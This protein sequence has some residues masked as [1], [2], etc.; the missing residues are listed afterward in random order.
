MR[1]AC[2]SIVTYAP[3]VIV[4]RDPPPLSNFKTSAFS[5]EAVVIEVRIHHDNGDCGED[6][7][8]NLPKQVTNSISLDDTLGEVVGEVVILT[9]VRMH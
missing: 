1:C 3:F 2:C 5:K 4:N 6:G 7:I 9:E 8:S